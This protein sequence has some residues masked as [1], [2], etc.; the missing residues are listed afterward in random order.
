M[1]R[2]VRLALLGALLQSSAHAAEQNV[3]AKSSLDKGQDKVASVQQGGL[4]AKKQKAVNGKK[5]GAKSKSSS[6]AK[7]K[8]D[9]AMETPAD[10]VEQSVQLKGVRG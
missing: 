10:Q 8:Q 3:D 6:L 2:T 4:K 9:S 7:G 1:K 5:P